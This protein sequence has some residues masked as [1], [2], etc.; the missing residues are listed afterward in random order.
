MFGVQGSC[1]SGADCTYAHDET[2]LPG[3]ASAEPDAHL[4][5]EGLELRQDH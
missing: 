2:E 3:G 4:V 5:G 1:N